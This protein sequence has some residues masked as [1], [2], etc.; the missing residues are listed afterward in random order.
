MHV[1]PCAVMRRKDKILFLAYDYPKGMVL[2]LPGGGVQ[3]GET[4]AQAL[5]RECN[6]ELAIDILV[7]DLLYVA[8]MMPTPD[9]GQTVQ[10]IF[11]ANLV[12]GE[13]RI[14]KQHTSADRVLW[15]AQD[16]LEGKH[17]YPPIPHHLLHP[18]TIGHPRYLGPCVARQWC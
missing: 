1:R 4:L 11:A 9:V 6:E 2:A 5:V 10:L 15:L 16:E 3:P 17:L 18:S 7:Q 13:P 14:Q 12:R 8:D